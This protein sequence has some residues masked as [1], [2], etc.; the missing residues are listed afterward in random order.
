MEF[1]VHPYSGTDLSMNPADYV[2]GR[3]KMIPLWRPTAAEL[4]SA[5]H[6]TFEFGRSGGTDG[7]PWTVKTDGGPGLA[8]DMTRVSAAPNIDHLSATGMG[9]IEVWTLRN[10][11]GGGW[12]HPI[13]VHFEEGIVLT[14]DGQAP[15]NPWKWARKDMF[16][17]GPV[18][19]P[20][21]FQ[22]AIHVREFAGTYVEHCH[23][24]THE[25]TAMLL[26]WD[27]QKAGQLT[28]I[29]TPIPAWDG[30]TFLSS[31]ALPSARTGDGIGP[32]R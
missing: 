1:R 22:I 8:A 27:S 16:R 24:T 4:S 7:K 31:S 30:C 11:S 20:R 23:N 26:R 10:G 9:H 12:S 28:T 6:R 32:N 18:E 5:I 13:H 25:D 17:V 29:A 14:M 3:A 19:G 2:E 15:R 21:E